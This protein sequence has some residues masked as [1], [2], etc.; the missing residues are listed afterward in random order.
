MIKY[1]DEKMTAKQ[2]AAKYAYLN[3]ELAFDYASERNAEA[4]DLMTEKEQNEVYRH[5]RELEYRC[6]DILRKAGRI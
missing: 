6:S 5:L 1:N 3:L 4:W 2:W